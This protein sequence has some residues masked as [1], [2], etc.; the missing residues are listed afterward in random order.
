MCSKESCLGLR[1]SL[2]NCKYAN[3]VRG[4]IEVSTTVPQCL[5]CVTSILNMSNYYYIH[6]YII[7]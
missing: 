4:D 7:L 2:S 3:K 6:T 1:L 5:I